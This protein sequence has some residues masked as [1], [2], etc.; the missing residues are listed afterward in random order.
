MLL[1]EPLHLTDEV[2]R[3]YYVGMTRARQRLFI[4]T[5]SA[6]FDRLPAD[7]RMVDQ[8]PYEMP[9]EIVLQLS[10]KDVNLGFFKTR[11]KEILALRAGEQLRFDSNYLYSLRANVPVAQLSKRMQADLCVWAEKGYEVSSST[12]RFIVAWRPKDAQKKEE[13]HAVL[14]VDLRLSKKI[15]RNHVPLQYNPIKVD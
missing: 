3:R 13:E 4:H 5:S 1:S 8:H 14:L 6:L 10:H 9:E 7:H 11:K 2:L 12:I 15:M